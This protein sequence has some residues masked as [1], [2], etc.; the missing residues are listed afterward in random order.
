MPGAGRYG[1]PHH[2]AIATRLGGHARRRVWGIECDLGNELLKTDDD[3]SLAVTAP[4]EGKLAEASCPR[5]LALRIA[6]VVKTRVVTLK[7]GEGFDFLG[8]HF[9][10]AASCRRPGCISWRDGHPGDPWPV[11]AAGSGNS[12]HA[13]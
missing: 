1:L 3:A 2:R 7:R 12:R 6:D 5:A 13:A 11:P 9:R 8:F 10:W 4:G